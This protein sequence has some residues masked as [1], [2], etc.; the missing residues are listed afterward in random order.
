M[1]FDTVGTQQPRSPRARHDDVP[2][3]LQYP[4]FGLLE[5][6][7]YARA[8]PG[9]LGKRMMHEGNQPQPSGMRLNFVGQDTEGQAVNHDN[10]VVGNRGEDGRGFGARTRVG[11]RKGVGQFVDRYCPAAVAKTGHDAPVV[12]VAASQRAKVAGHN[13]VN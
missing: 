1:R 13:H 6:L 8:E 12:P 11:Q 4:A 2:D 3:R 7:G 10:R 9:L 5:T